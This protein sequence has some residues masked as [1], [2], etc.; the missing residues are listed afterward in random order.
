M[1]DDSYYERLG[2]NK[3]ASADEIKKAY[4]KLALKYHPD[5]N[6]D[7]KEAEQKFKELSEAYEVLKDPE[8]RSAYDH[9]GKAAFEGGGG[10]RGGF[11]DFG[12]F[13]SAFA[14]IFE[15]M[16]GGM[17]GA[18]GRQAGPRRGSD[19]QYTMELTL[20]EA[21]NGKEAE[22][23]FPINQTCDECEG[24]GAEADSGVE[25]C[26]SCSGAG[27][28]RAQQGFFT[29]ERV[30]P[31]CHGGGQIIRNPCKACHGNGVVSKEKSLK[32]NIPPGVDSGRRIRLSG[33]GEAGMKGGPSGDLYVLMT[34]KP[35]N[36]FQRQDAH[37]HA[38]IP[39]PMTTAAL[40]GEI[41]VPTISGKT[42]RV[43]VPEGTQTGQ[44]IRLKDKGMPILRSSNFGDMFIEVQVET[45]VNL[46]KKQKELL[47]EL[48]DSMSGN[49]SKDADKSNS[50][51]TARFMDKMKEL[52]EDMT[53]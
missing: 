31:T 6:K 38:R 8:K 7:N 1:A 27:R 22:L 24:T 32:I 47:K 17:G 52:W 4:R 30:C 20:E 5:H 40:G 25:T 29:I 9:Y 19:I 49:K 11:Q 15:D 26:P 46:N 51:M 23:S 13:G 14:D 10:G 37:L 43:E 18:G 42:T 28:V 45:P 39:V 50:P 41:D 36:F 2:V 44:K 12:G 33:E 53:E 34:I 3:D 16:F 35:H 21:Y 48:D